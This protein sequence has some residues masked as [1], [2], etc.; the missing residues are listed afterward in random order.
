MRS[1]RTKDSELS[2]A[3]ICRRNGWKRGTVISGRENGKYLR[4]KITA[5]GR[6]EILAVD[7]DDEEP[8]FE[9]MADLTGRNWRRV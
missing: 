9:T 1:V 2:D 7:A 5:I 4:L 3:D 6:H 8:G